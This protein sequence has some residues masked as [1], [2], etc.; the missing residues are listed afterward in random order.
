MRVVSSV[1][2]AAVI[3]AFL[4]A[5]CGGSGYSSSPSPTPTPTPTPTAGQINIVGLAGNRSFNPNPA[6]LTT[7]H[8]ATWTNTDG[9]TH[10]IVAN[11]GSWDTGNIAPGASSAAIP[12][13]AGGTNY[14]C[15]LH[16]T[17]IGAV[18]D[19]SGTT[20]PCT[21]VYC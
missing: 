16:P 21:G 17:M 11:D 15:S 4:A 19:S 1:R 13:P 5:G 12:L 3:L 7:D 20:P 14:H 8:M 18:N 2:S 6:P 10:R 9:V